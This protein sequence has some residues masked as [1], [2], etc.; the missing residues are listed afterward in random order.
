MLEAVNSRPLKNHV[1]G[2][3]IAALAVMLALAT[4]LLGLLSWHPD[5]VLALADGDGLTIYYVAPGGDCG[6]YSPCYASIQAAVDAV[7]DPNDEVEVAA[8]I[9]SGVSTRA[10]NIQVL[11]INK[12]LTLSGG[13]TPTDWNAS[14][15]NTNPTILDAQQKGRVLYI[16]GDAAPVVSGLHLTGG[17]IDTR[18]GG[19]Y[20]ETSPATLRDSR[21]FSN[22]AGSGGGLHL[23]DSSATLESN[24]IYSNTAQSGAG[25]HLISSPATIRKNRIVSNIA[26]SYGGGLVLVF[27]EAKIEGNV[28][29]DN[30]ATNGS[31]L[32]LMYGSDAL[33]INNVIAD[34]PAGQ[35]GSQLSI[36]NA[37][38]RLIHNTIARTPGTGTALH[39]CGGTGRGVTLTNTIIVSNT[40]GL[41]VED[42]GLAHLEGVLWFGNEQD[43]EGAGTINVAHAVYGDPSFEN[44]VAGDYHINLASA[45]IDQAVDAGVATDIDGDTRPNG[46]GY[47]LGA[48]EYVSVPTL[49]PTPTNTPESP[50]ALYLP[51]LVARQ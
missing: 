25:L 23:S 26:E 39:L 48:D 2:R 49:T 41:S 14:N 10:G 27:S 38:P 20:I 17:Q 44:P 37:Y 11:Y 40:V 13:Y 7:D 4:A 5:Q 51:L 18:G 42:G 36:C 30:S 9:Y 46:Q 29:S 50:R 12:M 34:N 45:A 35:Y 32:D 19:V 16:A 33:L 1:A 15:P 43:T 21:I 3:I 8:G 28:V 47:D 31:G 22:T 24:F 6:G